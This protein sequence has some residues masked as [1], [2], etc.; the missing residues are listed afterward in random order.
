MTAKLRAVNRSARSAVHRVVALLYDDVETL[1]I[2]GLTDAFTHANR[3]GGR[4]QVSHLSM[5]G[6]DVSTASG[7]RLGV[8]RDS[9][10]APSDIDTLIVPGTWGWLPALSDRALLD[11][12]GRLDARSARTVGVGAGTFLLAAAGMLDGRRAVTHWELAAQLAAAYADVCVDA[13]AL[14][15]RDGKYVTSAGVAAT[16]DVALALIEDDH[17]AE[18]ARRV[19]RRLLVFMARPGQQAQLSVRLRTPASP[20]PTLRPVLDAITSNPRAPHS[21]PALAAL[22]GVSSRQLGRM[23]VNDVGVTP[24]RYVD[25]VRLEAACALLA[26]RAEPLDT[27]AQRSGIGSSESLSTA[28]TGARPEGLRR[29]RAEAVATGVWTPQAG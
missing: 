20:R 1:E 3:I 24:M 17:D 26:D 5:S 23:F 29:L 14:Y 12:V 21:V 13:T 27:I 22:I 28:R 7:V 25:Q 18:L 19:A 11:T 6:A 9:G 8:D 2:I 15:R 16:I 10:A 4:Y